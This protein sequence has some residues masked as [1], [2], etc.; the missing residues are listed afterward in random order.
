MPARPVDY[1]RYFAAAPGAQHWGLGL[2]A[3]GFTVVKPGSSY[4]PARH[5]DDH[6]FDWEHGRV[7]EALQLVLIT[8][9]RGSFESQATGRRSIQAGTA[10]VVLPNVWHRYRPEPAT[11]WVESWLEV[12]GPLVDGLLRAGV[13]QTGAAVRRV[14]AAADLEQALNRLHLRARS[15]GPGFDPEL[16]ATAFAV[17]A[18]WDKARLVQPE[19]SRVM[20]AV[21]EAER[22]LEEHLAEPVNMVDLARRCGLSYSHFRLA[23]RVQTGFPPWQY[24]LNLRLACARRALSSGEEKREDLACRLGF[25]SGFHLSTAFKRATGVAPSVWRR[26]FAPPMK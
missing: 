2:T 22:Y 24:V 4:P 9:G 26:R 1:F 17:L 25:S 13:F 20:R 18:A 12:R 21:A 8:D 10:F 23:F 11:G 16:A 14:P 3:A 6:Q 5:P 15:A 19:R 7:L